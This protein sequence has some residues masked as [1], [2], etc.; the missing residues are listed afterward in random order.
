MAAAEQ[1]SQEQL[2]SVRREMAAAAALQLAGAILFSPKRFARLRT[3]FLKNSLPWFSAERRTTAELAAASKAAAI[4]ARR[5][6]VEQPPPTPTGAEGS[7]QREVSP[8]PS[9]SSSDSSSEPSEGS[10]A[11]GDQSDGPE[12]SGSGRERSAEPSEGSDA[13][14]DS[15]DSTDVHAHTHHRASACVSLSIRLGQ[16]SL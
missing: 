2:A 6:R 4:N 3:I 1:Q 8:Q 10:E 9:D 11:G 7:L 12:Q 15:S 13:G 5:S 16:S 14:S